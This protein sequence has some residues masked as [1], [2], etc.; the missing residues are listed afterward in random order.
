MKQ[1]RDFF[2]SFFVN[3]DSSFIA[4]N[5]NDITN[6]FSMTDTN[7]YIY[8]FKKQDVDFT[9]QFIH[10]T[11]THVGGNN[12]CKK[13]IEIKLKIERGVISASLPGPETE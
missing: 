9:Y 13:T 6:K 11:T 5:T 3:L 8:K 4:I 7:L 2:T 1:I 10:G 12:N